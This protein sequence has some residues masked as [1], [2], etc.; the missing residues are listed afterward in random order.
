MDSLDLVSS[1]TEHHLP[2]T[3]ISYNGVELGA[4]NCA[5]SH[6]SN[7]PNG[8]LQGQRCS[9]PMTYQCDYFRIEVLI[10]FHPANCRVT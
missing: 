3:A 8:S 1:D 10:L 7:C 5:F 6:L 9:V 2:E 4:L